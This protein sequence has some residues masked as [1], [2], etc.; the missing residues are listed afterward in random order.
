MGVVSR[1]F[2]FVPWTSVLLILAAFYAQGLTVTYAIRECH[3]FKLVPF[4][5]FTA[6]TV[7]KCHILKHTPSR[8]CHSSTLRFSGATFSLRVC[9]TWRVDATCQG[10]LFWSAQAGVYD[11]KTAYNVCVYLIASGAVFLVRAGAINRSAAD[12]ASG[13][14]S[15]RVCGPGY[16]ATTELYRADFRAVSRRYVAV[17]RR[18][19]AGHEPMVMASRLQRGDNIGVVVKLFKNQSNSI[20]QAQLGADARLLNVNGGKE[21]AEIVTPTIVGDIGHIDRKHNFRSSQRLHSLLLTLDLKNGTIR[22][23]LRQDSVALTVRTEWIGEN[24]TSSNEVIR[25][26]LF[27]GTLDGATEPTATVSICSGVALSTSCFT[28][29]RTHALSSQWTR[30]PRHRSDTHKPRRRQVVKPIS[31][32]HLLTKADI[33]CYNVPAARI[34]LAAPPLSGYQPVYRDRLFLYQRPQIAIWRRSVV[35]TA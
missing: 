25:K 29:H 35:S 24:Y 9:A 18:F 23:H 20:A 7:W 5:R 16:L 15:R 4:E 19:V 31:P 8:N 22:L 13:V 11:P 34:W 17:S 12:G 21:S 6:H 28:K 14:S 1:R 27:E 3:D 10:S 33:A 30:Y 26:C 32:L 2:V